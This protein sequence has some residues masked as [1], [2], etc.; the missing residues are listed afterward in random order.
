MTEGLGSW[1]H[2]EAILP[3]LSCFS[4]DIFNEIKKLKKTPNNL[5]IWL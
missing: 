3:E 1:W 4:P 2:L 5:F